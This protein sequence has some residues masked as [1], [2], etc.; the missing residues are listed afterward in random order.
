ML[1]LWLLEDVFMMYGLYLTQHCQRCTEHPSGWLTVVPSIHIKHLNKLK[2]AN[3]IQLLYYML[4]KLK[5][6][7]ICG[8]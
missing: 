8:P 2:S 4:L 6:I 5:E 1:V 3:C 7:E